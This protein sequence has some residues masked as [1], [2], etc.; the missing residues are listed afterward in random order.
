[1]S[2]STIYPPSGGISITPNDSTDLSSYNL[3][4]LNVAV[5]GTVA[6]EMADGTTPIWHIAAGIQFP[7]MCVKVL[8]TGT[9]A[10]GI[11]GGY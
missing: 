5:T 8:A 9:T 2:K 7:C 4:C 10:T 3:R 6:V 11:V 1:M